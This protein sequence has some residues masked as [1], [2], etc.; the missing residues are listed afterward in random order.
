MSDGGEDTGEILI[1]GT[2]SHA[3]SRMSSKFRSLPLPS[4]E[5]CGKQEVK[6]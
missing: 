6:S 5:V 3:P 1:A 2:E 4:A